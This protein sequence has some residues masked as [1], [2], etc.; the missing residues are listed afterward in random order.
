MK[1]RILFL[2]LM[3]M[4]GPGAGLIHETVHLHASHVDKLDSLYKIINQS[5]PD[6]AVWPEQLHMAILLDIDPLKAHENIAGKTFYNDALKQA[7]A[8]DQLADFIDLL[9][10]KGVEARN[11]ASY[12]KSIR[13]HELELNLADSLGDPQK[14]IKALNNLA[15]AH[16][17]IDNYARASNYYLRSKSL[18]E[19]HG[20]ERSRSIA[21]NGLG[22]IQFM[23]GNYDEALEYFRQG[24]QLEREANNLLGM[25]INLNNIG[26]VY[27]SKAEHEKAMEFFML[28]LDLNRDITSSKGIAINY[29]DIGRVYLKRNDPLRALVF[30]ES[31]IEHHQQDGDIF[32]LAI[33]YKT[34]GE[35]YLALEQ[36]EPALKY[37]TEGISLA[38][39]SYTRATLEQVYRL[40]YETYKKLDKPW[41]AMDYLVLAHQTHD[42]IINEETRRTFL[43]LMASFDNER[44]QSQITLLQ[45]EKEIAD[46]EIKRQRDYKLVTV[47]ALA[48]VVIGLI[49]TIMFSLSKIRTNRILTKKNREIEAVQKELKMYASQLLKAKE[50]AEE[51]NKMKSRFLANMSHE[52]RTPMNSVIGF[53]EILSKL[54]TDK[55]QASYLETIRNS[56]K[57]LLVLIND[58]LDL[59][60]IEAGKMI[61]DHGPVSLHTLFASL[62]DIFKP[63]I[64]A[65]QLALFTHIDENLPDRIR[66]SE[67]R[68]RQTLFNLLGN[69]IKFTDSGTI[70][71]KAAIP[72]TRPDGRFELMIEVSDTGVGIAEDQQERIFKAFYQTGRERGQ[73]QGT[74]LGLAITRR[75]VENMN[76]RIYVSSK[77]DEGSVFT[78]VFNDVQSA[79]NSG[80]HDD[81]ARDTKT[82]QTGLVMGESNTRA[83]ETAPAQAAWKTPDQNTDK[84]TGVIENEELRYLWNKALSSHFMHDVESLAN[85]ILIWAEQYGIDEAK[86]FAN[87]LLTSCKSFDIER[88]TDLLNR[89]PEVCELAGLSA[90]V[91]RPGKSK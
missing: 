38:K 17:R 59:S 44:A 80:Q 83:G 85:A 86:P 33:S 66:L 71:L 57:N 27:L 36:Y 90:S 34:I 69:A 37:L 15:V 32:Y 1:S 74:G 12:L 54:V 67:V 48:L 8:H 79:D 2:V 88:M 39:Q 25:A 87:E 6:T 77:P 9:D 47:L 43:Q 45:N 52:I 68:L 60:K 29:H 42:S 89:F 30:M 31:A 61:I 65:K 11:N 19:K 64:E 63:Q 50:Q 14:L 72:S 13:I 5:P 23:I 35:V 16:R 26:N 58:I 73:H 76:G 70:K 91:T 20:F 4:A 46:L 75:L 3:M 41:E 51:S 40:M 7:Q 22:N 81:S 53:T 55:T 28:S 84:N 49:F 10:K 78:L 18:A 62:Q 24:L 21:I 82:E 56:S